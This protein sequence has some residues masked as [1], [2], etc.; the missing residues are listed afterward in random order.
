MFFGVLIKVI[1]VQVPRV[2]NISKDESK[3]KTPAVVLIFIIVI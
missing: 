3:V 2:I 1:S